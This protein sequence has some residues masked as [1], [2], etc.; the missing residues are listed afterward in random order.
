MDPPVNITGNTNRSPLTLAQPTPE[1]V[2]SIRY[3]RS[4][5]DSV[6]FF[7]LTNWATSLPLIVNVNSAKIKRLCYLG[8]DV[9]LFSLSCPSFSFQRWVAGLAVFLHF[10]Q[11]LSTHLSQHSSFFLLVEELVNHIILNPRCGRER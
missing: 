6:D 1:S 8:R 11:G 3:A 7:C 9:N 5:N 2:Y 4:D 10:L